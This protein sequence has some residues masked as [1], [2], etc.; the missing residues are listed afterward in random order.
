MHHTRAVAFADDLILMI[1]ADSIREAENI[2]NIYMGKNCNLGRKQQIKM[3][4]R[5]LYKKSLLL[6]RH[7]F[8]NNSFV[9]GQ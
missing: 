3:C 8:R 9:L 1:R 2:A 5:Y 7:V 6:A 4:A